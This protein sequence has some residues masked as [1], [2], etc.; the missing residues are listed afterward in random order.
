MFF[1]KLQKKKNNLGRIRGKKKLNQNEKNKNLLRANM[2]PD[3]IL[4]TRLGTA[5]MTTNEF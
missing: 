2:K 5:D 3:R 1:F 4:D